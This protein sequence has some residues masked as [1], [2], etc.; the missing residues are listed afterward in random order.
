MKT[1]HYSLASHKKQKSRYFLLGGSIADL[2]EHTVLRP[3]PVLFGIILSLV[4][5]C[6]IG[7]VAAS[8]AYRIENIAVLTYT[9]LFGYLV[10][11]FYEYVKFMLKIGT[12]SR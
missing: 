3:L 7:I 12:S 4:V 1:A 6:F 2:L 5:L 8:H 10:G 9:Y 11:C